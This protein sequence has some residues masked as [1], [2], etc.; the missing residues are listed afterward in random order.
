MNVPCA[1]DRARSTLARGGPVTVAAPSGGAGT[2]HLEDSPRHVHADGSV[3]LLLPDG[4]AL[5]A[6]RDE[7]PVVMAEFADLSPV[8]LRD[9]A[10]A[11]LWVS[12]TLEVLEHADARARAARL[13]DTD[14]D[15]R[16][17][18]IG[19]GMTM[20]VL[21]TALAVHSDPDGARVLGPAELAAARPDPFCRWEGPWLRHLDEDHPDLLE[22]LLA[23]V[24]EAPEGRPRPLGVD[25]LGLRL[26]VETERGHHD[27][28]L[29]FAR[30][31][32]TPYEVALQVHW[33]AGHPVPQ[34]HH[35]G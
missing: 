34:G 12:G 10:R 14:P 32:R 31:A 5:T 16:L 6:S 23:A 27:V 18:R 26:R 20:V 8:R 4:H 28:R 29:P 9:R 24:P 19:H 30:P 35:P 25:R 13:V 33:L 17:L 15:D 21:R 11:V 22:D 1:A 7:H 3:S 2:A